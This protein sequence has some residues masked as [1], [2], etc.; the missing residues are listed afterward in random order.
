MS[1]AY[2]RSKIGV[3]STAV[4]SKQ[5]RRGDYLVRKVVKIRRDRIVGQIVLVGLLAVNDPAR[6][7]AEAAEQPAD[8][9]AVPVGIQNDGGEDIYM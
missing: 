6:D 8:P 9:L 5:K 2:C 4:S 7:E 3:I 1:K